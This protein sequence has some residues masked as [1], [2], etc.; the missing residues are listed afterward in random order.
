LAAA[1]NF[2]GYQCES[3]CHA[4]GAFCSVQHCSRQKKFYKQGKNTP[5][6]PSFSDGHAGWSFAMNHGEPVEVQYCQF[7]NP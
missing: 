3:P 5:L 2:A 6:F 7:T 1:R 4:A